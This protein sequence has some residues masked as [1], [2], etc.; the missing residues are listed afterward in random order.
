[1]PDALGPKGVE[2]LREIM[3]GLSRMAALYQGDNAGAVLIVDEVVRR[4]ER[5]GIA[6]IRTPVKSP[7]EYAGALNMAAVQCRRRRRI[8]STSRPAI[9]FAPAWSRGEQGRSIRSVLSL[10]S[11]ASR[12]G[13]E[14]GLYATR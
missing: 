2:F 4:G 13:L 11:R 10:S 14:H 8:N 1:M 9:A 6:F 12:S 3:P 7:N 5:L